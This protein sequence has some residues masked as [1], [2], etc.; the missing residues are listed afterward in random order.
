M[1][2]EEQIESLVDQHYRQNMTVEEIKALI[3]AARALPIDAECLEDAFA[4]HAH[5]ALLST[6]RHPKTGKYGDRLTRVVQEA[7]EAGARL[8]TLQESVEWPL[9]IG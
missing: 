8:T 4:R 6:A 1:L 3:R 2:T 9:M 7:F 5:Q